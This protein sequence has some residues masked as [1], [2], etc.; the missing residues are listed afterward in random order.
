MSFADILGPIETVLFMESDEIRSAANLVRQSGREEKGGVDPT[1]RRRVTKSVP[2]MP[3]VF[4]GFLFG[5]RR[6]ARM[7]E[8]TD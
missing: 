7:Q 3:L 5:A 6:T 8:R 1:Q 2:E 4:P